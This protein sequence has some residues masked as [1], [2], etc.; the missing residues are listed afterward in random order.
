MASISWTALARAGA[1]L[2]L[3]PR[4]LVVAG[5]SVASLRLWGYGALDLVALTLGLAGAGLLAVAGVS[6]VFVTWRVRR[7][8]ARTAPGGPSGRLEAEAPLDTGFELPLPR[9]LPFVSV[10]W[11]WHEPPGVACR[12][13]VAGRRASERVTAH[14]RGE[15]ARIVRAFE[16]ADVFGLWRFGWHHGVSVSLRILPAPR[17]LRR[18]DLSRSLRAGDAL[19]HPAGRPEGDRLEIRRYVPGDPAR[20]ILWKVWARTG[21]LNVRLPERS[22]E[23]ARH[24]F[25]YL[26]AAEG[27]EPA[28]AAARVAVEAGALGG[29]WTL[30]AD[31]T[32]QPAADREAAL[33]AI[34]RSGNAA[35]RR[36]RGGLAAFLAR[37]AGEGALR[38]IV[39][40]PALPGPWVDEALAAAG[41]APP[42]C[43]V[44]G[45]EGVVREAAPAPLWRRALFTAPPRGGPAPGDLSPLLA[46]LAAHGHDAIVVDRASGR[47]F[48]VSGASLLRRSA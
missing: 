27:D 9:F 32:D 1:R 41:A 10:D 40:A 42:L 14:A 24:T 36:R 13:R 43:F 15:I 19:A 22:L 46:R 8:L 25:A 45:T 39:F 47:S 21:R 31:G 17:A 44:L 7:A 5:L 30:G 4:G 34:A 37:A 28:A 11:R 48:G 23:E 33:A 26:V 6:A 38:C 29:E 2:P 18:L 3:R 20:H 35:A 16:V 12:S